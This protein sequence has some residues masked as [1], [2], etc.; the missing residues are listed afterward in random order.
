MAPQVADE[1]YQVVFLELSITIHLPQTNF[2]Q[3]IMLYDGNYI[4]T[5]GTAWPWSLHLRVALMYHMVKCV[6]PLGCPSCLIFHRQL[7]TL[8]LLFV[9]FNLPKCPYRGF[10][11]QSVLAC[12]LR[13]RCAV[14]ALS[15]NTM[16]DILPTHTLQHTWGGWVGSRWRPITLASRLYTINITF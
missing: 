10:I 11:I 13:G 1:A 12:I 2:R 8:C 15:P 16:A 7:F 3:N 14:G 9:F 6:K 5:N 4:I